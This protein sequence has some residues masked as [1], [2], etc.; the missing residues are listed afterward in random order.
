M[1]KIR[2]YNK[3]KDAKKVKKKKQPFLCYF[4]VLSNKYFTAITFSGKMLL[5]K[6][7]FSPTALHLFVSKFCNHALITLRQL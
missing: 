4:I 5:G 3:E 1:G 7:S 2:E 6:T